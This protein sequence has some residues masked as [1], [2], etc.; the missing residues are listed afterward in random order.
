MNMEHVHNLYTE[1]ASIRREVSQIHHE[2][3]RYKGFVGGILWAIA[4]ASAALQVA[5][6]WIHRG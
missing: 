5:L 1:I 3:Q 2:L 4:A 6:K